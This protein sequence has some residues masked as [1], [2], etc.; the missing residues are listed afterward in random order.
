MKYIIF[1]DF[2]GRPCPFIFPDKIRHEEMREQ[3]PYS[4]VISAG[5]VDMIGGRLV[6]HGVAK[7]LGTQAGPDDATMIAANFE[8]AEG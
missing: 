2:S 7:E 3:L 1:E 5:Y 8:P 4:V 6:C